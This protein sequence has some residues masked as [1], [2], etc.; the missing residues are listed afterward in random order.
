MR[1]LN[2]GIICAI[3]L[4]ILGG[5]GNKKEASSEYN[6]FYVN[7][8]ETK[9]V[10]EAYKPQATETS[11]MVDEF[12]SKLDENPKDANYKKAK[13][14][15]VKLL[16]YSVEE[17]QVYLTF[18]AGY[19]E[20]SN[21]TEVLFRTAIVRMLTQI[22]DIEFVSF[23]INDKPLTD[24]N[25]NV[26]GIMKADNF[27]E[28]T[29]DEINSYARTKLT[30]YYANE[31]GNKLIETSVDVVY[32]SNISAEKLIIEQLIRGPLTDKVYPTIPP[33]T[34]LNSIS[35]KDGVCYV[36]FDEGFLNPTYELTE[37]VPVYSVVNSLLELPSIN[38]VQILINGETNITYRE[39][40]N[41]NTLFERNLDIIESDS[42]VTGGEEDIINE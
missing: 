31:E 11:K 14:D 17:K 42:I 1:K 35:I 38:K 5:C 2:L 40:I 19:Y 28:N 37:S 25:G 21:I 26:V 29:S 34:K 15:N 33:E 4:M 13:P 6:M 3:L 22:P 27:I 7:K 8:D 36:N 30:L 18:D 41:F 23:Y 24:T 9:I 20:M 10:E 39:A 32:T 12:L 16:N